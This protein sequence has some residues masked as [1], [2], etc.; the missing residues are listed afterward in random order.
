MSFCYRCNMIEYYAQCGCATHAV[1]LQLRLDCDA[2]ST[3]GHEHTASTNCTVCPWR[4]ESQ[5]IKS[6]C[7]WHVTAYMYPFRTKYILN[8]PPTQAETACSTC[9]WYSGASAAP[10]N[11]SCTFNRDVLCSSNAAVRLHR[12]LVCSMHMPVK[13]TSSTF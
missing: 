1:W 12:S 7:P 11:P 2:D 8:P 13:V 5:T 10:D 3:I 6:A 9:P 4:L